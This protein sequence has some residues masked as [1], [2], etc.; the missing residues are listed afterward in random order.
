MT[1]V[2]NA[3]LLPWLIEKTGLS[4]IASVKRRMRAKA[5]RALVRFTDSAIE[6]LKDA[7]DEMLRGA[8]PYALNIEP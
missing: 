2:I 8:T 4:K 7:D 1:L 6:D 5:K 3:P